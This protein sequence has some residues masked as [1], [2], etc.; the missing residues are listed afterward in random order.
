MVKS[1]RHQKIMEIIS[2]NEVD[3]QEELMRRLREAGFPVTQAT[4]SRDIKD[5][6]IIKTLSETGGYR[7]FCPQTSGSDAA[8]KFGAMLADSAVSVQSAGNIAAVKCHTGM[9]QAVCTALDSAGM[10]DIVATLAGDD[11]I[12]ILCQDDSR[13]AATAQKLNRLIG[14]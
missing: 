8:A 2:G 10:E 5:L 14:R 9:A 6:R 11:T 4:V 3:T 7:Y 1:A 12:F 13:A